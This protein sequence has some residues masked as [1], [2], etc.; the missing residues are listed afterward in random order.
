MFRGSESRPGIWVRDLA[1]DVESR[2]TLPPFVGAPAW[3]PDRSRIAFSG[4]NA[5]YVKNVGGGAEQLLLQTENTSAPS[6]WSRDGKYLLYTEIDP[7]THGDIW[8]LPFDSSG[9]P[10][11]PVP[12]LTTGFD[13]SLGQFSPDGRWVA[14]V[15]NESGKFEIYVRQFPS[16]GGPMRISNN[17]GINPR[18]RADGKELYYFSNSGLMAVP[19]QP[20]SGGLLQA[21]VPKVLFNPQTRTTIPEANL[22]NYSPAADGQRFL[23]N[24]LTDASLPTLN[25]ITNWEDSLGTR[26]R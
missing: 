6:D 18:W 23:M 5:L 15:S 24:I 21:G 25:V 13:E 14:Y 3:S 2:F 9:K 1:R 20:G 4:S 16:G 17:G 8:Y 11:A 19:M 22:F 26:E 7:K 12:F 10:G